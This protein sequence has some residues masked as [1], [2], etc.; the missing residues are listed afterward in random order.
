MKLKMWAAAAATAVICI[1]SI[2]SLPAADASELQPGDISN[3]CSF[4]A[5]QNGSIVRFLTDGSAGTSWKGGK[6]AYIQL[7]SKQPIGGV[8]LLWN[9]KPVPWVLSRVTDGGTEL[10]A[11][12]GADSF[13]H[14]FK[15]LDAGSG[16][17]RLTFSDQA[18]L[19]ELYVLGAG[20]TPSWV[21][22]WNPPLEKADMLLA[23]THADDELLWFG[24]A[25]PVYAGQFGKKVQVS[26]LIRHGYGRTHE[27]LDGLWTVGITNYPI[28]SDFGDKY[29]ST[30]KQ[31]YQLYN[32]NDIM[33]WQVALIRRVKPDVVLTQDLNGEYGHGAHRMNSNT[34]VKAITLSS[35]PKQYPNS[36]G[37]YGTWQIKKLYLHKYDKDD[38]LMNWNVP[39]SRFGGKTGLDMARAGF[40]CHISQA[41]RGRYHVDEAGKNDNRWFGLY[42]SSVGPDVKK[43]DFFE[44][45][46]PVIPWDGL[47]LSEK[48]KGATS[49]PTTS[50]GTPPATTAPTTQASTTF[51]VPT[52]TTASEP[53]ST[54][55]A[56]TAPTTGT[57]ITAAP[58]DS[59]VPGE[60]PSAS[61]TVLIA[62]ICLTA[63]ATATLVI[64]V[65]R[66]KKKA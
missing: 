33:A 32:K 38:L 55:E 1:T 60:E 12:G 9:S 35:D 7:H 39:L 13:L 48:Q 36:A 2:G 37:K 51:T 34:L 11:E 10:L 62:V 52:S 59:S 23:S 15:K 14:E 44:N 19:G 58:P 3:S 8:Y 57:T 22:Q 18:V 20:E 46:A 42:Y 21:Q 64:L 43:N 54:T 50:M 24:G 6:E 40:A 45:L 28:L 16:T 47:P 30:L 17:Y 63:G 66:A 53:P 26:Y 27:L 41:K 49:V 5:S 56:V 4:S 31:A 25:M 65:L 29:C 61:K